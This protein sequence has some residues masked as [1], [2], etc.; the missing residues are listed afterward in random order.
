MFFADD[1]SEELLEQHDMEVQRMKQHY[2][3]NQ[4]MFERVARR[5]KLWLEFLEFEVT[6]TGF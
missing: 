3:D 2:E 5:Q 1:F 6:L 4:G